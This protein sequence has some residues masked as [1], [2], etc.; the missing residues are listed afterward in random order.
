M[1]TGLTMASLSSLETNRPWP[2]AASRA[3]TLSKAMMYALLTR[4]ASPA[5]KPS[6]HCAEMLSTPMV[7]SWLTAGRVVA[8]S[9]FVGDIRLGGM[10]GGARSRSAKAVAQ[11]AGGCYVIKCS[12]DS[13]GKLI[14][15]LDTKT[16][17]FDSQLKAEDVV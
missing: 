12:E 5:Q 9:W 8:S 10:E 15:H 16:R 2:R 14:L 4:T 17:A 1:K 7:L 11:Q 6:K 3:L 13:R